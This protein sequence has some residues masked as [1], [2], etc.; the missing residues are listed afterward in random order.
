M[1]FNATFEFFGE[2]FEY[3]YDMRNTPITISEDEMRMK[4]ADPDAQLNRAKMDVIQQILNDYPDATNIE[5]TPTDKKTK[6]KTPKL[7]G[8]TKSRSAGI[9]SK[10]V[11]FL[12]AWLAPIVLTL[13]MFGLAFK[14]MFEKVRDLDEFKGFRRAFLI[15]AYSW[16]LLCIWAAFDLNILTKGVPVG[17]A[18]IPLSA[19]FAGNIIMLFVAIMG[20]RKILEKHAN[21]ESVSNYGIPEVTAQ[22][23]M[24]DTTNTFSNEQSKSDYEK[25]LAELQAGDDEFAGE[26]VEEKNETKAP[27]DTIAT[28]KRKPFIILSSIILAVTILMCFIPFSMIHYSILVYGIALDI[29]FILAII[30]FILSLVKKTTKKVFIIFSSIGVGAAVVAA[31]FTIVMVILAFI[32]RRPL[33][34]PF[35]FSYCYFVLIMLYGSCLS[36]S[37]DIKEQPK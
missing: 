24:A 28:H 34:G 10:T 3:D 20:Q 26:E 25:F 1:K 6:S 11:I 35:F 12:G 4:L 14:R 18:A 9:D 27:K 37:L 16:F 5:I 21:Q 15:C 13:A 7:S 33:K 36:I 31:S 29:F 30:F 17:I 8:K 23:E 19:F 32:Q 22:E 2:Q